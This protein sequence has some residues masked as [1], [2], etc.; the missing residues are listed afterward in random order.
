MIRAMTLNEMFDTIGELH[1]SIHKGF[2][3]GRGKKVYWYITPCSRRGLYRVLPI[4][5]DGSLGW[6]RYIPGEATINV[7]YSPVV[8]WAQNN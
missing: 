3:I 1:S 6:A 8:E 5:N 2:S 7:I 4:E